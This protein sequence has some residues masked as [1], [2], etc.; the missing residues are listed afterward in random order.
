MLLRVRREQLQR[1][2]PVIP[3]GGQILCTCR[4]ISIAR[5]VL[6]FGS[7]DERST[8]RTRQREGWKFGAA[9]WTAS[10]SHTP[11]AIGVPPTR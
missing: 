4:G 1:E 8:R 7:M 5:E 2:R 9:L 6:Q 11:G 3:R 10:R